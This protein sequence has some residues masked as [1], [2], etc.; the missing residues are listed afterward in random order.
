MERA[1][2]QPGETFLDEFAPAV[3]RSREFSAVL[4]GTVGHPADVRLVVLADVGGVGAR[5]GTLFAH[6]RDSYGGVE[7]AGE[8]DADAFADGQ[9]AEHLGHGCKYMHNA[10]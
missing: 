8:G 9:G 3:D 1:A 4:H 7:T 2:R 6:P 10:A 5:D